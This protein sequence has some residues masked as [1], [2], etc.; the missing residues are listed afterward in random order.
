[1]TIKYLISSHNVTRGTSFFVPNH[2]L[3]CTHNISTEVCEVHS[4]L[5]CMWKKIPCTIRVLKGVQTFSVEWSLICTLNKA[6]TLINA[7]NIYFHSLAIIL[8][9]TARDYYQALLLWCA[10]GT[11]V[12][13]CCPYFLFAFQHL[14]SHRCGVEVKKN[15]ARQQCTSQPVLRLVHH[16]NSSTAPRSFFFLL[17]VVPGGN[18]MRLLI[19]ADSLHRPATRRQTNLLPKPVSGKAKTPF[20]WCHQWIKLWKYHPDLIKQSLLQLFLVHFMVGMLRISPLSSADW[21][22]SLTWNWNVYNA[23]TQFY[24]L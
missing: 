18:G 17:P 14:N 13:K 2:K 15:G 20:P 24:C 16:S 6:V 5:I 8:L 23:G 1:M 9:A 21:A 4:H 3:T 19:G 11:C 10:F 22:T 12:I 7:I